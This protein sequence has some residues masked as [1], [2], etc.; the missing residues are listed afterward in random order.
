MAMAWAMTMAMVCA[1]STGA[2]L[3]AEGGAAA[4]V[5][6]QAFVVAANSALK[7]DDVPPPPAPVICSN[8]S[9]GDVCCSLNGK[10]KAEGSSGMCACTPP[11]HGENCEMMAFKPQSGQPA[12]GTP[13]VFDSSGKRTYY[14][15][16]T[17]GGNPV[18][19]DGK[20]HLFASAMPVNTNLSNWGESLVDHAISPNI[21]GP[22]LYN[23]TALVPGH[24]PAIIQLKNGSFALFSILD[25]GVHTSD[26]PFG[27][28]TKVTQAEDCKS[29]KQPLCYCN[30]PSPWLHKNGTIFL[31]C[32]GGGPNVDGLWRSANLTGP[33]TRV[34]AHVTFGHI[35]TDGNRPPIGGGFE[36]P[37]LYFDSSNHIHLL[38][39]SF[40]NEPA[41][42][43]ASCRGTLTS[44]HAFSQDGFS[45]FVGP[46]VPYPSSVLTST[47]ETLL[48]WSRERPKI[49]WDDSG[50]MTHLVTAVAPEPRAAEPATL[51]YSSCTAGTPCSNCKG[52]VFTETLFSEFD[53]RLKTDD[54]EH[55]VSQQQQQQQLDS[56]AA[57]LVAL[58][59]AI[60][61]TT[62]PPSPPP[63][64]FD[65]TAV[66]A[67]PSGAHDSTDA[68][69]AACTAAARGMG[70]GEKVGAM[71]QPEVRFPSGHYKISDTINISGV[72]ANTTHGSC[73]NHSGDTTWCMLTA[74]QIMGEGT[75]TIEQQDPT[76]DI[77]AGATVVRIGVRYLNLVGG[78]NQLNLGNNNTDQSFIKISDCQFAN[79]S[80]AAIRIVGPSCEGPTCPSDSHPLVGSFSSQVIVRDCE[81][82]KC[83]QALVV[84]SD[85]ASF[86]DSWI[87]GHPDMTN[88][89]IIENHDKIMISKILG[90]P[91][92]RGETNATRQRWID[93]YSHRMDGGTVHV[94]D[95]RFGGESSGITA[96][97]NFAPYAC[98][99]VQS[100]LETEMCGRVNRSGAI[101]S[102]GMRGAGGS[103]VIIE[104]SLIAG[105]AVGKPYSTDIL[106]EEVPAQLV[107]R[108]NWV[109]AAA[110]DGRYGDQA[111][112]RLV[113]A[114]DEIDLDGPYVALASRKGTRARPTFEISGNWNTPVEAMGG[115]ERGTSA[116][117][118][119][120]QQLQPFQIGCVEGVEPPTAGTWRAGSVVHNRGAWAGISAEQPAAWLCESPGTPG[121]WRN[122]SYKSDDEDEAGNASCTTWSGTDLRGHDGPG[123]PCSVKAN[124]TTECCD[125]CSAVSGCVGWTYM[126]NSGP[127]P[128]NCCF[129]KST[130]GRR[131]PGY[132]KKYVSG[133]PAPAPP[134]PPAPPAPPPK[135]PTWGPPGQSGGEFKPGW[136]G[137]ARRRSD[138]GAGIAFGP[139]I[140]ADLISQ[141][142]D[143]L[144]D[145]KWTIGGKLMS[146]H[147]VGYRSI[148]IDEGWELCH[149]VSGPLNRG[150]H[151][152]PSGSG[153]SVDPWGLGIDHFPNGTPSVDDKF[154]GKLKALVDHGHS[155]SVEMGFYFNGCAC[156]NHGNKRGKGSP[157]QDYAGDV[158]LLHRVN[159]DAVKFDN[160]GGQRNLT[161]YAELMKA[162]GKNFSIENCHWGQCSNDD[163]SSCP[164]KEWAP[165][166]FF[167]SSSDINSDQMS[168][169]ENLQTTIRFSDV[170]QPGCW[171]NPDMLE[172]GRVGST[173]DGGHTG[174]P[175]WSFNGKR[176]DGEL[177]S[178]AFWSLV[179][180]LSTPRFGRGPNKTER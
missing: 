90:V 84:W 81:F 136:N 48:Y 160:C 78:R 35:R 96:L 6:T 19:H 149:N 23:Q 122:T 26:T 45:W 55:A 44:A 16:F 25:Y 49:V 102:S 37:H 39:H 109:Q 177:E 68:I 69:Q 125:K 13:P 18:E 121:R 40:G 42:V 165:F 67:D 1:N 95:V 8:F 58:R 150:G 172:V 153:G 4:V 61:A 14:G 158:A 63:G 34:Y 99:E 33:W 80:S 119:L 76:K 72:P 152:Q 11:W 147:D 123:D 163:E 155:K 82:H 57:E 138:G 15:N 86:S 100:K 60:L 148:G 62:A 137:E 101:P 139:G 88:M 142:I 124:S 22:Y 92:N 107:L 178:G 116:V 126:P 106:L 174:V 180:E 65:V 103:S 93:N 176:A 169:F 47:N 135:P 167:R 154:N 30:N 87:T 83:M 157:Q 146:L 5:E 50:Q 38:F 132:A 31:A 141:Q 36:D 145:C 70:H 77:I 54:N 21:T 51:R 73:G 66:G 111:Q 143:A 164:S 53:M 134:K 120:P 24:N 29:F 129:K 156:A 108:D 112:Y 75:A 168:W 27:P 79:S 17:W 41:V 151:S 105:N 133:T 71:C 20:Y 7:S 32:G 128:Y 166:N 115:Y 170:S 91:Q 118:D 161:K 175:G 97:V 162:S 59:A 56:M 94:R 74:L 131:T 43:N 130:A 12:Y 117:F 64:M 173:T 10:F 2:T 114:V 46:G 98:E 144:T 179:R 113:R 127:P 140:D 110:D 85:W 28:W 159:F 104:G 3:F 171:A 89:A 52:Q 9:L